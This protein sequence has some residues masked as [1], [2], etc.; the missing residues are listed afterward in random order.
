MAYVAALQCAAVSS[1]AAFYPAVRSVGGFVT[2]KNFEE[3]FSL[4][5]LMFTDKMN[6]SDLNYFKGV[7]IK[8]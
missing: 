5:R 3:S 1:R 6:L 8:H 4:P 7:F 2:N